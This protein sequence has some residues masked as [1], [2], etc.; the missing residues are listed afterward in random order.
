MQGVSGG[1]PAA[2]ACA[3][4]LP[5]NKLKVVCLVCGVGPPDIG[6]KGADWAHWVGWPYGIRFA[7]YCKHL[8]VTDCNVKTRPD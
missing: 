3:Y 7:P 6:M 5:A 2:L 8:L 4:A 1:G